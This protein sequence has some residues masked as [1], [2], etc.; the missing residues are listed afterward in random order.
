LKEYGDVDNMPISSGTK[1]KVYY[2]KKKIGKFSSIAIPTDMEV[3]PQW[4]IDNFIPKIDK[5]KQI[6]RLVDNP[7]DNILKALDITSPTSQEL[8]AH[9]LFVF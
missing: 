1:I 8:H 3:L 9:D 5:D 4:F 7:L 6:S 2:L